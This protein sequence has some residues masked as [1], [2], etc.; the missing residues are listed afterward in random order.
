MAI[1]GAV[2]DGCGI[3]GLAV[4]CSGGGAALL[5]LAAGGSAPGGGMAGGVL[6][7]LH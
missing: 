5:W 7:V 6:A 4:G 1:G 2:V 3:G